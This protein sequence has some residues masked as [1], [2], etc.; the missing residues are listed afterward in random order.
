VPMS[1]RT[2]RRELNLVKTVSADISS[3]SKSAP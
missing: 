2:Q 1:D 3:R